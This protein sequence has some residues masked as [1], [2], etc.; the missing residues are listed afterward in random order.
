MKRGIDF[1]R[2]MS[3]TVRTLI[4][5]PV[6]DSLT[7]RLAPAVFADSEPRLCLKGIFGAWIPNDKDL[8]ETIKEPRDGR[9]R[10]DLCEREGLVDDWAVGVGRHEVRRSLEVAA[11]ARARVLM[12]NS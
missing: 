8:E 12:E 1:M 7:T 4:G 3:C 11:V 9:D 10:R 2:D 5:T 6:S